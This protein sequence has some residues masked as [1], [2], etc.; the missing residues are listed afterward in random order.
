MNALYNVCYL[1]MILSCYLSVISRM[2]FALLDSTQ[3]G[4]QQALDRFS[5]VCSVAGMKIST[6]KTKC[7]SLC[8]YSDL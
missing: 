4:L 2:L 5:D 1:Q 3:N 8:S 6:T 7:P